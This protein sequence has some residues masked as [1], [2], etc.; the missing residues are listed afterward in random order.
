MHTIEFKNPLDISNVFDMHAY[1][2]SSLGDI[3]TKVASKLNI[4]VFCFKM[5]VCDNFLSQVQSTNH[6]YKRVQQPSQH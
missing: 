1:A 5:L 6:A 3:T 2:S 4:I